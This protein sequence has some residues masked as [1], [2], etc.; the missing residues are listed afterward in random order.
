MTAHAC[1]LPY[2]VGAHKFLGEF[3]THCH[4]IRALQQ[5]YVVRLVHD[6]DFKPHQSP[7]TEPL[8][9]NA[10][11]AHCLQAPWVDPVIAADGHTYERRAIQGH[12]QDHGTSP[13]N[14]KDLVHKG[15]V[16][17]LVMRNLMAELCP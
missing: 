11:S 14:K 5:L 16:P 7:G 3:Q 8:S 13:V 17:N 1:I 10:V 4:D 12:L 9:S 2:R 15:L 6:H